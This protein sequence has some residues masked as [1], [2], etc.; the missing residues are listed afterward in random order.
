MP[1]GG[2]SV[3]GSS[4]GVGSQS[5]F[6]PTPVSCERGVFYPTI[7][8]AVR[9]RRSL[10]MAVLSIPDDLLSVPLF[11]SCGREKDTTVSVSGAKRRQGDKRIAVESLDVVPLRESVRR[12]IRGGKIR[13]GRC[14]PDLSSPC[15]TSVLPSDK[16]RGGALVLRGPRGEKSPPLSIGPGHDTTG[17]GLMPPFEPVRHRAMLGIRGRCGPFCEE[18][19]IW[20]HACDWGIPQHGLARDCQSLDHP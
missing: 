1:R 17:W 19:S 20:L 12:P 8:N 15:V 14:T 7:R 13:R 18:A 10:Q 2:R 5:R 6:L 11:D 4:I 16:L 9:G 3:V